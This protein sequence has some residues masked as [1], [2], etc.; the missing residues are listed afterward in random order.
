MSP[1][2]LLFLLKAQKGKRQHPPT[3]HKHA[4]TISQ[5]L[6]LPCRMAEGEVFNYTPGIQ[7]PYLFFSLIPVIFLHQTSQMSPHSP[8]FPSADHWIQ[9]GFERAGNRRRYCLFILIYLSC[10]LV[11]LVVLSR[12]RHHLT[13]TVYKLGVER[14]R[15]GLPLPAPPSPRLPGRWSILAT[16]G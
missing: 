11:L 16:A 14:E 4:E 1:S 15:F 9:M 2:A 13:P 8:L 6:G 12:G 3:A 5:V 10:L 7:E